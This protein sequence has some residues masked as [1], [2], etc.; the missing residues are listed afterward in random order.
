MRDVVIYGASALGR[1]VRDTLAQSGAW[2]IHGYLDSD[3]A[4]H[5]QNI[6][7][8]PILGGVAAARL[9]IRKGVRAMIVAVGDSLARVHLA[10]RLRDAGAELIS[11]IH[12]LASVS[13]SARLG[14]HLIIG[15]RAIICVHA[16]IGDHAIISTGAIVEHDNV[17]GRAA[18][19]HPAVRLAGGVRVG[20]FA[21]LGI[22]TCVIPGR[23]IG[24]R[25]RVAPGAVVIR[26][27]P[28]RASADGMPAMVR[29]GQA[30]QI[31]NAV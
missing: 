27:V 4:R 1:M 18:F 5:H 19:L 2:R 11:A 31:S 23:R 12:P 30:A 20:A 24:R 3:P 14:R 16:R 10:R 13:P 29:I 26:D 6:D 15:A 21:T 25:A 28:D 7:N 17:V 8:L 9:L 22:G